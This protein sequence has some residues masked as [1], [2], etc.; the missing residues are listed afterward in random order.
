MAVVIR[1][2]RHGRKKK[3]FYRVVAA[4]KRYAA[5]GKFL[6]VLGHF[7][8]KNPQAQGTFKNDRYQYWIGQGAQP[9]ESVKNLFKRSL[10]AS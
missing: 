4:D 6:E 8:P 9:S 10:K 3:P 7:D 5:T 1:L 2:A